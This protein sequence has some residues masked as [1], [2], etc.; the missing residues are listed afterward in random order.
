MTGVWNAPGDTDT[1]LFGLGSGPSGMNHRRTET[2]TRSVDR[3]DRC[4]SNVTK[5]IYD[6]S[7]ASSA[8]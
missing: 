4:F 2:P 6:R 7:W 3:M 8:Y 1:V 5:Y